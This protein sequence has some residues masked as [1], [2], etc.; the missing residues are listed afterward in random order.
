MISVK[1][2]LVPTDFSELA[3]CALEY[4]RDLC[5]LYGAELHV[6]H[7]IVPS[8]QVPVVGSDP[9]V[10]V[11][12]QVV[13]MA[14]TDEVVTE[15]T[16]LLKAQTRG[17]DWPVPPVVAVRVGLE[18]ETIARYAEEASIDLIVVGT[19][20]RSVVKRML[21]GSTSKAVLE[22]APCPV[23][24]VPIAAVEHSEDRPRPAPRPTAVGSAPN[25]RHSSA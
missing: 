15:K 14:P 3:N 9:A 8:R 12:G 20:A 19:H 1:R 13:L 16:E 2:I 25:S 11:T 4:A 23:L 10:G 7:V 22:H 24:M 18:W 6:L 5:R 21:L 17:S